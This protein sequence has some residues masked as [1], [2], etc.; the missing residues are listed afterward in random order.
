MGGVS[1]GVIGMSVLHPELLVLLLLLPAMFIAWRLYPPPLRHGRSRFALGLRLVAVLVLVLALAQLR[2]SNEPQRRVLVAVVD[3]SASVRASQEQEAQ[4]VRAL[5]SAKGAD[6]LFGVVTFGRDV[7]VELAPTLTPDFTE[8]QT[9]PDPSYTDIASALQLAANLGP[10]GYARQVVLIGDGRQNLGDAA[11]A[12]AALHA[13]GVR[14]DVLPAGAPPT[15]EA[16]VIGVDAPT[17]MRA[18]QTAIV[19]VRLS[20]TQPASGQLVFA[21][22]GHELEARNVQLPV[23]VST[24]TFSLPSLAAGLYDVRAELNVQPDTYSENNIGEAVIRVLGRPAVLI[25]EG[26][27]GEGANIEKALIAGGMSVDRKPARAT[28]TD[29]A[30]LGRY[31]S[32]V[33]V[34]APA[35]AFPPNGMAAIQRAVRDL[36]RGLVTIGGASSY[37]PGGWQGTPLETALPVSMDLPNRKEK[38]KVAVVLVMETMEDPRADQVALGAA[39]AVID[40]L[41]PTDKVE[42]TGGKLYGS[43]PVDY[44]VPMQAVTDKK[45]IDAKLSGSGLGDP[46]S[47]MPY[48]QAAE[49]DLLKTDAPLKH[50]VVLG[51]GDAQGFGAGGETATMQ[52]LLARMQG[53]GITTSSIGINTHGQSAL[54]AYMSDIARFGGGHFYESSDPSQ[55]PQLFLKEAQ[56]ALRPWFE[57]TPF[58]PKLTSSGDLLSG[59]PLDAFPQLGGYVVTTPKSNA[60]VYFES[61]KADPVLAAWEY[62]LGRSVAWTSDSTGRWTGGLLTSSAGGT[63][64]ARLVEWTLPTAAPSALRLEASPSGDTLVVTA[65]G[66]SSGGVLQLSVLAPDLTGSTTQLAGIGPGRW[67]GTVAATTVGTYVLHAVLKQG[68]AV[69]AQSEL[70]VSVPYSAEFVNLG[71]DDGLLRELAAEGGALL[72]SPAAAWKLPPVS[73]PVSTEIFWALLLIVVILWPLD[74]ALRRVVLSPRQF[75]SVLGALSRR[76]RP[77]DVTME[78]PPELVRLRSRVAGYRRRG[79]NSPPLVIAAARDDER[80]DRVTEEPVEPP[81]EEAALSARLLEARRRRRE[82]GG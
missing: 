56:V 77:A 28:P 21:V 17:E 24:Q 40:K 39:Q 35:D 53:E 15:A 73:V 74:V 2:V 3:L 81:T 4:A 7:Q 13:Q 69:V 64:F 26:S 23:G 30:Q 19:T 49:A 54:M 1:E 37:G 58:F 32:I 48:L 11:T 9:Q 18:G 55:V 27:D 72:T 41:S 79:T 44:L 45:A 59:V 51:D 62:G 36:G 29:P 34:N 22:G 70:A 42:V 75:V 16:L 47:Y 20:S 6:D 80:V 43:G 68:N 61:P 60:D 12:V 8:F 57:Q 31:D 25:L 76:R 33:V 82:R 71:R 66:A 52:A 46:P 5:Q 65:S 50:V 67:Q 10:E 63:L 78:V 14:V 38:P